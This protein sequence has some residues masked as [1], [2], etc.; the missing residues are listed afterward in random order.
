[1]PYSYFKKQSKKSI[2]GLNLEAEWIMMPPSSLGSYG[3]EAGIEMQILNLIRNSVK[4]R[5]G[6]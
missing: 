2:L 4:Y 3:G 6:N 5:F 1:M